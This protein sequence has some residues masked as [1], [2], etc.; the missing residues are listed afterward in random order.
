MNEY[1]ISFTVP[2][3]GSILFDLHGTTGTS[4]VAKFESVRDM[5][6]FFA[7]L[8][9]HPDKVEELERACSKLQAGE[10]YHES[11]YLP[12]FVVDAVEDVTTGHSDTLRHAR[13]S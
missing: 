9:L 10:A 5:R 1:N 11:M 7:S 3:D 4:R 6:G 13:A 2:D 8:G 12:E